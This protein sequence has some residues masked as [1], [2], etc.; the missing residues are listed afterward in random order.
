MAVPTSAES[1]LCLKRALERE[2][3]MDTFCSD[4]LPHICDLL[5]NRRHLVSDDTI[6]Q[7]LLDWF[8]ALSSSVDVY[9]FMSENVCVVDM[10]YDILDVPDEESDL[11]AFAMRLSGIIAAHEDGFPLVLGLLEDFYGSFTVSNT[12]WDRVEV[13]L[14]WLNGF[15]DMLEH[16]M[17]IRFFYTNRSLSVIL[18]LQ[19]ERSMFLAG[20]INNLVAHA[21]TA[22][23]KI[24]GNPNL[25]YVYE[26]N[27]LPDVAF[28]LLSRSV[29]SL[30][31]D[32][33]YAASQ[34]IR[35]LIAIFKDGSSVVVGI[36]W[37]HMFAYIY[38]FLEDGPL[39]NSVY[40]EE[41]L[42]SVVRIPIFQ[43]PNCNVWVLVLR[44]L[45]SLHLFQSITFAANIIKLRIA[46]KDVSYHAL[47]V[48]LYPFHHILKMTT[49]YSDLSLE[50]IY[51]HPEAVNAM[52][53]KLSAIALLSL[54]F[55]CIREIGETVG[56]LPTNGTF[57][58]IL[59]LLLFCIG[60][61]PVL[62][63]A[64]KIFSMHLFGCLK[65][66]KAA[67][68]SLT[69][70]T[71]L[72][73]AHKC[74]EEIYKILLVYVDYP[75]IDPIVLKKTLNT[76]AS[77]LW[78][79]SVSKNKDSWPQSII[80]LKDLLPLLL[81]RLCNT[82]W[83]HRQNTLDYISDLLNC[84]TGREGFKLSLC[85]SGIPHRAVDLLKDPVSA[86][87]AGAVQCLSRLVNIVDLHVRLA[88]N[89]MSMTAMKK[90]V[91]VPNF[92]HILSEDQDPSPRRA[93]IKVFVDWL[94]LGHIQNFHEPESLLYRILDVAKKDSDC[95]V[96]SNAL[97][98]ARLFVDQTFNVCVANSSPY[99][100]E[101]PSNTSKVRIV[102]ALQ[103]LN[104]V[105]IFTYL[106]DAL[107]DRDKTVALG[108]CKILISLKSK[109]SGGEET[110]NAELYGLERLKDVLKNWLLKLHRG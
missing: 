14:A 101:L 25:D 73:N 69:N 63:P 83:E 98:L 15:Q 95:E 36:A 4:L 23:V 19:R 59:T 110:V 38:T 105:G 80:F 56:F 88:K 109:L 31:S 22:S 93:V 89:A 108:A 41:L 84:Y 12:M 28:V 55:R 9:E 29:E 24:E 50:Q 33:P 90:K 7:K 46:P 103:K 61:A 76:S 81:K 82:H 2:T 16:E 3:L 77:W 91:I 21:I 92:M 34:A 37:R 30:G 71:C 51:C 5:L 42:L 96:K 86:V 53:M 32:C 10:L 85:A 43:A 97:E 11:Y 68:D 60:Q 78:A 99:N 106:L 49:A 72:L 57:C 44:T 100:A 67:L 52:S 87:R 20:A 79:S 54:S 17:S 1:I 104:K 58:A 45:K 65:L 8:K 18:S 107:C 66:Q 75:G 102:G 27:E 13:K 74:Q 47:S 40:L 6:F 48:L 64:G 39:R 94:I 62:T 70:F 26:L 35:T